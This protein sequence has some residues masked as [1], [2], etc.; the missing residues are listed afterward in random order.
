MPLF[1]SRTANHD[2][3]PWIAHQGGKAPRVLPFAK[4][5]YEGDLH[6]HDAIRCIACIVAAGIFR[7]PRCRGADSP[8]ADNRRHFSGRALLQGP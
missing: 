6:V 5:K 7:V 1:Q 4:G 2:G 8:L 3:N